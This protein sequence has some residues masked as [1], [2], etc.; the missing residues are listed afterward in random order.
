MTILPPRVG[1]RVRVRPTSKLFPN[2]EGIV[3][4]V[5]TEGISIYLVDSEID[6][7]IPIKNDEWEEI[8]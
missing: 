3:A 8:T 6:D 7:C 5:G 4:Y 1:Q 2:H